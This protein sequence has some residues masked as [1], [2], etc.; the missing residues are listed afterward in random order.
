M[1][2]AVPPRDT[3]SG[4]SGTRN[5]SHFMGRK[6]PQR[7]MEGADSRRIVEGAG[8]MERAVH[9]G[10]LFVYVMVGNRADATVGGRWWGSRIREQILAVAIVVTVNQ[11]S[12]SVGG[13]SIQPESG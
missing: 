5:R 13:G 2:G 4:N 9:R 1:T 6:G 7:T 8:R 12:P 11:I 3:S 10:P